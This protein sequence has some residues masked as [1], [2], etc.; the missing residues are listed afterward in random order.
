VGSSIELGM[1]SL[2][3]RLCVARWRRLLRLLAWEEE[4]SRPQLA[5]YL[6]ARVWNGDTQSSLAPG[7][8]PV[9]FWGPS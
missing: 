5:A 7:T 8:W 9:A 2:F 3:Y 6:H 1:G 4:T